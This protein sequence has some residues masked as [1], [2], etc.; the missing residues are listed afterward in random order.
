M[1]RVAGGDLLRQRIAHQLV[2]HQCRAESIAFAHEF[3]QH[4]SVNREAG[5]RSLND[6][7][8]DAHP[9]VERGTGTHNAVLS[10]HAR[11][12][13]KAISKPN[14]ERYEPASGKIDTLDRLLGLVKY[15]AEGELVWGQMRPQQVAVM[16]RQRC[17]QMIW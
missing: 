4:S 3:A 13:H 11:F 5:A 16:R 10:N 6:S 12:D 7:L 1:P 15:G 8:I 9:A 2:S 14:D 17:Q